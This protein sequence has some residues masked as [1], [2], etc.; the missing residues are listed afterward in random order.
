MRTTEDRYGWNKTP[1]SVCARHLCRLLLSVTGICL[2]FSHAVFAQTADTHAEDSSQPSTV[3]TD[4][5]ADYANPSRTIQ[6][7]TQNGNRTV[8]V[9]SL[10][11]RASD[12]SFQPYQDIE[13]ET[14]RVNDTITH[15]TTRTFVRDGNGAKALFQVTDEENQTLPGG[16]SKVVRTTSNPDANGNLQLVQREVQETQKTGPDT[17]ETKTTVMLPSINGGLTPAMQT[18]EHQKHTGNTVEIQKTTLLSDGA[19]TWQVGEV[20]HTT[21]NSDDKNRGSEESVSRPDSEG[22]LAEITRTVNKESED[23]SGQKNGSEE[24]YSV[25]VPGTARD[26]S[27]HLVQRVTTTQHTGSGNKQSTQQVV[28]QTNPGNPEA[29]LRVTA[30]TTDTVNV[31]AS[32]AQAIRTTQVRDGSGSLGVISVDMSKSN[33]VRAIEVQ[34]A[35]SAPK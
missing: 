18:Q 8:D 17:G 16:A 13:T 22:K 15:S 12:G 3:T 9:R 34:I 35:P 23:I 26:S 33:S 10:Q 32:G 2:C 30:V 27:L 19:G 24:T 31:G 28:E 1:S 4:S 11:T 20:R 6:T 7:H 5:K 29:G 21:I 25:D 14:V